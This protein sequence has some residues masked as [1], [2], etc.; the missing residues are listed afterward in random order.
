M[1]NHQLAAIQNEMAGQRIKELYRR[2]AKLLRLPA[3]L[4]QR[5]RQ[6][7]RGVGLWLARP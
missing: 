7:G 6:A 4:L 3:K 1:R 5:A 2:A